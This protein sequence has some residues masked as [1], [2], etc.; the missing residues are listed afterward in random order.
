MELFT[1]QQDRILLSDPQFKTTV[2]GDSAPLGEVSQPP[3]TGLTLLARLVGTVAVAAVLAFTPLRAK[4][5]PSNGVVT[6][7]A[8][9]IATGA[10]ATIVTQSSD[11]AVIAW[12]SFNLAANESVDFIVP[13]ATSATLNRINDSRPSLI[14]GTITSNGVVYFTNP[15]GLVFDATSQVTANGFLA[16]TQAIN[17][18][19]FMAGGVTPA[20]LT[21]LGR[22]ELKIDG[23]ITAPAITAMGG[24]VTVTGSLESP[25]GNVL[26]SSTNLTTIGETAVI[27]V[28]AAQNGDAGRAIIWSDNHTDYFGFISAQG[29]T[30]SGDGGF[31]EVSGKL[32][33]NY[34]GLVNTLAPHGKT[35]T[36][37]LDP[38]DITISTGTNSA[39]NSSGTFTSTAGTSIVNTTTLQTALGTSNVT[40]DANSG[41]GT[42]SGLITV[43][44]PILAA[45]SGSSSLTLLGAQIVINANITMASGT[46]LTLTATRASVWQD[47]NTIITATIISGSAVGGFTLNGANRITG[48]GT[49]TNSG[50]GGISV[51]NA[52]AVVV[53]AGITLDG[54][55]GGVSILAPGYDV[56][57]G[58]AVTVKGS[59]LR[60]DVGGSNNLKSSTGTQAITATGTEA[61]VTSKTTGN[62]ATLNLGTGNFIY[63]TDNRSTTGATTINN[64]TTLPAAFTIAGS[65]LTV[66]TTGT[67]NGQGVVY[68]GTVDI[69]GISTGAAKDLRYIEGTGI[70]VSGAASTFAG[71]LTLVGSG[72]GIGA[73]GIDIQKY[74]TTGVVGDGTSNLTLIQSGSVSSYGIYLFDPNLAT[75]TISAGGAM[76]LTQSGK[77]GGN[78]IYAQNVNQTAGGNMT[79]TQSGSAGSDGITSQSY[80]IT[81]GGN[82]I[83]TQSGRAV[84]DGIYFPSAILSAGGAMT[85][86][87]L[88]SA[89]SNGIYLSSSTLGAATDLSLIQSGSVG[90]S[91]DGIYMV[92]R[93]GTARG[94]ALTFA[95][96]TNN[97]VTF[98]TNNQKLSLRTGDNFAVTRGKVRID[99]GTGAMVSQTPASPY[100]L[101]AI[102]L[103]V[104]Y[105]G[106]TA[107]GNSAKINVG[108]GSFTFVNDRRSVTTGV[109]LTNSTTDSTA[110]IGWGSG[111]GNLMS[112]TASTSGLTVTGTDINNQGVVYG[113]TVDI[114][115]IGT[116]DAKNLRYIEGT[117]ILVSTAASTFTGSLTLVSSGSVTGAGIE[118]NTALTA[119]QDLNLILAGSATGNGII[120]WGN[121][122]AGRDLNLIQTGLAGNY[123]IHNSGQT[124]KAGGNIRLVQA[125]NANGADGIKLDTA[126]L[127][128]GGDV[129]LTS[130]GYAGASG[131]VVN[132][133]R[134]TAGRSMIL[135]QSGE[136]GPWGNYGIKIQASI[137]K[138]GGDL[139]LIQSGTL[140]MNSSGGINLNSPAYGQVGVGVRFTAGANSFVTFKTNNNSF[141]LDNGDDFTVASGRVRIDLGTGKFAG[142]GFTLNAIGLDVFYTGETATTA[143]LSNNAKINVGA[144]S[145]TFVNDRR[146]VTTAV[147]LDNTT[148]ASTASIGWGTGLGTLVSGTASASDL[149][150]ITTGT[151][152]TINNQGVVYGSTVD[153]QGISTGAAKDLTY[154]EGTGIRVSSANPSSF[155]SSLTLVSSGSGIANRNNVYGIDIT[156]NLNVGAINDGT[157]NLSL[158]Q[159]GALTASV[160]TT[161]IVIAANLTAGGD[162]TIAQSGSL[163]GANYNHG[164]ALDASSR[165]VVLHGGGTSLNWINISTNGEYLSLGT[166]GSF[167]TQLDNARVKIDLGG[168]NFNPNATGSLFAPGLDLYYFGNFTLASGLAN[169]TAINLMTGRFIGVTKST[170]AITVDSTYRPPALTD[171]TNIQAGGGIFAG[172]ATTDSV[173]VNAIA[174]GDA[175]ANLAYIEG[176]TVNI[177]AATSFNNALLFNVTNGNFSNTNALTAP[178]L[179]IMASGTVTIGSVDTRASRRGAIDIMSG[180][181]ITLGARGNS[182]SVGFIHLLAPQ[183]SAINLAANITATAASGLA[184]YTGGN[185]LTLSNSVTVS[186]IA[187]GTG[188]LRL[189]LSDYG[190]NNG[191]LDG[192]AGLTLTVTNLTKSGDTDTSTAVAYSGATPVATINTMTG[193]KVWVSKYAGDVFVND[194]DVNEGRVLNNRATLTAPSP[195]TG[196]ESGIAA[197]GRITV[198]G[199]VSSIAGRNNTSY[200]YFEGNG[201]NFTYSPTSTA[202]SFTNGVNAISTGSYLGTT[203]LDGTPN[204]D[205]GIWLASYFS[206]AASGSGKLNFIQ[207]GNVNSV[208]NAYGIC[209]LNSSSIV[210]SDSVFMTQIGDVSTT[211]SAMNTMAAG[212]HIDADNK[213]FDTSSGDIL[214]QNIGT[215]MSD[216]NA[217][218]ILAAGKYQANTGTGDFSLINYG[219]II[220]G[221]NANAKA[222]GLGIV[223]ANS[224][225]TNNSELKFLITSN[226]ARLGSTG[227]LAAIMHDGHNQL[228]ATPISPT[229]NLATRDAG[230]VYQAD[231][232]NNGVNGNIV[233][234]SSAS[235][236][237]AISG[238]GSGSVVTG[239]RNFVVINSDSHG[240]S[241]QSYLA[242]AARQVHFYLGTD[243]V[244]TDPNFLASPVQF[245]NRYQVNNLDAS[246]AITSSVRYNFP[247]LDIYFSGA[248]TGNNASFSVGGGSFSYINDYRST[249][250]P[251]TLNTTLPTLSG[252]RS[253][254]SGWTTTTGGFTDTTA[255]MTVLT[256]K[257][258]ESVQ[259]LGLAYGGAVEISGVTTGSAMAGLTYIEGSTITLT[260]NNSFARSLSLVASGTAASGI[261]ITG[262]LTTGTADDGVSNLNIIQSGRVTAGEGIVL[263]NGARLIAGGYLSLTQT[264]SSSGDAI[265]LTASNN[266]TAGQGLILTQTRSAVAGAS[267]IV[268]SQSSIFSAAGDISL[269]QLGAIGS[270]TNDNGISLIS[271]GFG[272]AIMSSGPVNWTTLRTDNRFKMVAGMVVSQGKMRL[273]LGNSK[274][275][276]NSNQ[277][278]AEGVSLYLTVWTGG[279]SI[280]NNNNATIALGSGNLIWVEN[281]ASGSPMVTTITAPTPA[282]GGTAASFNLYGLTFTSSSRGSV[283]IGRG[284]AYRGNVTVT[285]GPN[286]LDYIEGSTINLYNRSIFTTSTGIDLVLNTSTTGTI[287][288]GNDIEIDKSLQVF[289][290]GGDFLL[291]DGILVTPPASATPPPKNFQFILDAGYSTLI[292][293][294]GVNG[295][296][297]IDNGNSLKQTNGNMT[298]LAGGFNLTSNDVTNRSI[299]IGSG[300]FATTTGAQVYNLTGNVL[301]GLGSGNTNLNYQNSI[302]A[303]GAGGFAGASIDPNKVFSGTI[304]NASPTNFSSLVTTGDIWIDQ[305]TGFNFNSITTTGGSIYFVNHSS[306]FTSGLT[307]KAKHLVSYQIQNIGLV[308]NGNWTV[309]GSL[310]RMDLGNGQI[311]G[312][313]TINAQGMDAFVTAATTGNRVT[314]NLGSGNFVSVENIAGAGTIN[315]RTTFPTYDLTGATSGI[316]ITT[317]GNRSQKGVNYSGVVTLAGITTGDAKNLAYIEGAGIEVTAASSFSGSLVMVASG[318]GIAIGSPP[319][320]TIHYGITINQNLTVGPSGNL[321]L[322]QSGQMSGGGFNIT[323]DSA[324]VT[325]AGGNINLL[326][327]GNVLT[328]GI[329][330][331]GASLTAGNNI[332]LIQSANTTTAVGIVLDA[333]T[334]SSGLGNE[335]KLSAGSNGTVLFSTANRLQLNT[336][337]NFNLQGRSLRLDL[338]TSAMVSDRPASPLTLNASGMDVFYT[339]AT[340]GNSAK[341]NVGSGSFT[342]VNDRRS[343]TTAVT[344]DHLTADN[345]ATIGWGTGLGPLTSGTASASG[346]TVIT[347]GTDATINYQGVVYGGT[348]DIQGVG[349]AGQV[350]SGANNL[351]YI[352]GAGIS[353]TGLTGSTFAGSLTLVG[354]GSG[355]ASNRGIDIQKNLTTVNNLTL[356][357]SGSVTDKGIYVLSNLT[358]GGNITLTQSGSSGGDGIYTTAGLGLVRLSSGGNLTL[359]QSGSAG[360]F[361][362]NLNSSN[363]TAGGAMTLTQSG[364]AR[365]VGIYAGY[366]NLTAGGAMTLTQSGSTSA[367]GISATDSTL[368]AGGDLSLNQ[369]GTVGSDGIYLRSSAGSGNAQTFSAGANGFLTFKTNNQK[370]SLNS[371]D[372]FAVTSGRVRID[373]GTGT[374][375]SV[376]PAAPSDGFTLKT[377]GLDVFYTGATTGNNATI[378]VGSGSFTFVN[379]KRSVTS[380]VTLDNTTTASTGSIG[381]GTAPSYGGA[382]NARTLGGLTINGTNDSATFGSGL[383]GL[384]VVY[385]DTVN[386]R[387]VGFG[388]SGTANDLRYIEGTGISLTNNASTFT[389]SL[390]L[391]SSGSGISGIGI[392]VQDNLTVGT[393]L[394]LYQSGSVRGDGITASGITLTAGGD[395]ALIQSGT[396]GSG[397]DGIALSSSRANNQKFDPGAKGTVTFKTNNQTLSL[398]NADNFEVTRGKVRIDLGTG[399]MVSVDASGRI[400]ATA[401]NQYTLKTLGLDVFYTGSTAANSNK[402]RIDVDDG[403]FIYLTE[404]AST[405]A[406]TLTNSTAAN[407]STG[408]T[409]WS[410]VSGGYTT[411]AGM[412][413]L[414]T[415]V[416]STVQGYG[417]KYGGTVNI[418]GISTGA[419]K[420][421][422]YIEGAGIS[423]TTTASTFAGSLTLVGSGSGTASNLGI[424]I[425]KDLTTANNLTLIQSGA[426]TGN[427]IHVAGT[428]ASSRI[429]L[430][431]GGTMTLT[432][433]GSASFF[434]VYVINSTMTTS[435]GNLS[436]TQSGSAGTNGIAVETSTLTSTRGNI[437]LLQT[438]TA[439]T[440][441][442]AFNPYYAIRFIAGNTG[443]GNG[444]AINGAANGWVTIQT[445]NGTLSLANA[446]NFAVNSGRVRIDL[447][448]GAM[449]SSDFRG[450]NFALVAN[451]Y[452]LKAIGL[453]VF[454]TG[455]TTGNSAKIDVGGKGQFYNTDN[456]T[457]SYTLNRSDL[458]ASGFGGLTVTGNSVIGGAIFGTGAITVSGLDLTTGRAAFTNPVALVGNTMTFTG[459]NKFAD[460][461]S[462]ISTNSSGD[463][464]VLGTG[465]SIQVGADR[466]LSL[467]TSGSDVNINGGAGAFTVTTAGAGSSTRVNIDI[468]TGRILG[469]S[470]TAQGI[471]V[472]WYSRATSTHTGTVTLGN[473]T[474][475]PKGAFVY[476]NRVADGHS[477]MTADIP[478]TISPPAGLTITDSS[479]NE[480]AVVSLGKLTVSGVST[481]A[482]SL[483]LWL[484]GD[485]ISVE[486]NASI[487]RGDLV[488]QGNSVKLGKNLTTAGSITIYALSLTLTADITTS[489]GA[490]VLNLGAAGVYDNING[491]ALNTAGYKWTTTNQS[492]NLT[493]GTMTVGTGTV[494]ALG[495]GRLTTSLTIKGFGDHAYFS[496][497]A[498]IA[499]A[500]DKNRELRNQLAGLGGAGSYTDNDAVYY[501]LAELNS[502][503]QFGG[504]GFNGNSGDVTYINGMTTVLT[505]S[506]TTVRLFKMN[507]AALTRAVVANTVSLLGTN[508]FT[509]NVTFDTSASNGVVI[510]RDAS[511][512]LS[513]GDLRL[514]LGSG[515]LLGGQGF[516]TTNGNVY[517]SGD[518]TGS[519]VDFEIGSGSFY[520]VGDQ[521]LVTSATNLSSVA[522]ANYGTATTWSASTNMFGTFYVANRS[523][524]SVMHDTNGS[525]DG[526]GIA[527]G[528]LVTIDGVTGNS[529][530]YIEANG[531]TLSGTS[532]F[533]GALTLNS[534]G[535]DFTNS[536]NLTNLGNL[537][538]QTGG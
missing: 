388:G 449:V 17:S 323:V 14:S 337:S 151:A 100:T 411:T 7:G 183:G 173:T 66:T 10:T 467:I 316:T 233:I 458:S 264:G 72:A 504:A 418:Q 96:G 169:T 29:G 478:A 231:S 122:T 31:V 273:D 289:S 20:S 501:S 3:R 238:Y 352:D 140:G 175:A 209:T 44:D 156:A 274:L 241:T 179:A 236:S 362:I 293:L 389:G 123:G 35:G 136:A 484:E 522:T 315:D 338:G 436:L 377:L 309:S 228:S 334:A 333:L 311:G 322:V 1:T 502:G 496:N 45:T 78:G 529:L 500:A 40:I 186:N 450:T 52:Q 420:N 158:Y 527:Y 270:G 262:T 474:G 373:L 162:I 163:S 19:Q 50:S 359:S 128:A 49:I 174:A 168:G 488:L 218:G 470:L 291:D 457:G 326:Q 329:L 497:D 261:S 451:Q 429:T 58:G 372:N 53:V 523:L 317:T 313:K 433:S 258:I 112:G 48:V 165:N 75:L 253:A 347:T 351:R 63:V 201:L 26:V 90:S 437:S 491:V 88:G 342:F 34:N 150:V 195:P 167:V 405:S 51:K 356:I 192:R 99:L 61:F 443:V 379:D 425:Q 465:N 210:A 321:W 371:A 109:T 515:R 248:V 509:G 182:L 83:L 416:A 71:S 68:G 39:T 472:F 255:G 181:A 521:R 357:Q 341:I 410:T 23:T 480:Q 327:S 80:A 226:F 304:T 141:V 310:L 294:G 265:K 28:D 477:L 15:N 482:G 32:T 298:V 252:W 354:S 434:G 276:G 393:N 37:L 193:K 119:G 157:S 305:A 535:G 385:G 407:W 161:G 256:N 266:L 217:H 132:A 221:K 469:N 344:L 133:S 285:G 30:D 343:V 486:T 220:L 12:D 290:H 455:A 520:S 27:S 263:Q 259:G 286:S 448:T 111:L 38:T 143:L 101:N 308:L 125:G 414:T 439:A 471:N 85:L 463:G 13:A 390:V 211:S 215:T 370:L 18:S 519:N 60:L 271:G 206:N 419:V 116:G 57:L 456:K 494:F 444:V 487:F 355:T 281:K 432:Q 185:D 396:V 176:A 260:T 22:A 438:G 485:S 155:K 130:S 98:K 5:A 172:I 242:L 76:T 216:G 325:A 194:A 287:S 531:I 392:D 205:F 459:R 408:F 177:T 149:T 24:T 518:I 77:A 406:V 106:A 369:S 421:L 113:S 402:A 364:S 277:I 306:S 537:T 292:N 21:N 190:G 387:R 213:R 142:N 514:W 81:A 409:G 288:L 428:S 267:G 245:Q 188:L 64:R 230:Q 178:S 340:T 62:N 104:F 526:I 208:A 232:G 363:L 534:N 365:G 423:V 97:L 446:D 417:V 319:A 43:A 395:I 400:I 223:T 139:S 368:T 376:G 381:W 454:Y 366:S 490:V 528:G 279:T 386:I 115:S 353:V 4:A 397:K 339:S 131:I 508:S 70:S 269:L 330:L 415:G 41:N 426:V 492:L 92:S 166:T 94:T 247:I 312:G 427:G 86:T 440:L 442:T 295:G 382:Q 126:T 374:M 33:L 243:G 513:G 404:F 199:D 505:N 212:I 154:I 479:G 424:D 383:T 234:D 250:A 318:S 314:L 307:L 441:S 483:P 422:S 219:T 240:T 481:A 466:S 430:T 134:M 138:A 464:I 244:I 47:P 202:F 473:N 180:G 303:T 499:A 147:T 129:I 197:S 8:A 144:G 394:T 222:M 398:N 224:I 246:G 89:G 2:V 249:T 46:N 453:D 275:D 9:N 335:V 135:T 102:G 380:A 375:T 203:K 331:K 348:V 59:F 69:L 200:S 207:V 493:A 538:I 103:D 229:L 300:N 399:V 525:H 530:N 95:A 350:A 121:L 512:S 137:Q 516:T 361:G 170:A 268:F 533:T 204:Q 278:L 110:T 282:G 299:N 171:N 6:A 460:S 16:A 517:F 67:T 272:R 384:G 65:G 152:A 73:R 114:Q 145:F 367:T 506:D 55:S 225:Q 495:T 153:I 284:V 87:Q 328:F 511:S 239:F 332:S 360:G 148:T 118:T 302:R 297:F 507:N 257:R 74:L 403:S 107:A 251:L 510:L 146:S 498:T 25:R 127:T 503:K 349:S 120:P 358:A 93:T 198:N 435:S 36:L 524:L 401:A 476:A 378:N 214:V 164:I 536:G 391:V 280:I 79:M 468:G 345:T 336:T 447:G 160:L 237:T 475:G 117:G 320:T 187:F 227:K 56:T 532:S 452:S 431:A 124:L 42:G 189:D 254:I 82:M 184:I 196:W 412:T 11:R 489:G 413:V 324:A 159:T 235:T 296:S 462:L 84:G 54:G 461:L 108:S 105:T 346:L 301:L 191:R 283:V 445:K 91:K